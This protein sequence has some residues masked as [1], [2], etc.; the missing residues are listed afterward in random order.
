[1]NKPEI[2]AILKTGGVYALGQ[3]LRPGVKI[4]RRSMEAWAR[5]WC[6]NN[7][8]KVPARKRGPKPIAACLTDAIYGGGTEPQPKG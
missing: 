8:V 7:E 5:I 3:A 6:I 1:M 2:Q 4:K